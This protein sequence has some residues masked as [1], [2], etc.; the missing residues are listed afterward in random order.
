M[1]ALVLGALALNSSL[2]HLYHRGGG[3]RV[4]YAGLPFM[5][6][7]GRKNCYSQNMPGPKQEFV[8]APLIGAAFL[9]VA[10]ACTSVPV[11]ESDSPGSLSVISGDLRLRFSSPVNVYLRKVDDTRLGIFKNRVRVSPGSHVL[12]VDCEV[13]D[14]GGTSRY[15]LN[16]TTV[17][18]IDYRLQAV[19]ASG[20]RRCSAVEMVENPH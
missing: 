3:R 13:E 14:A 20:N 7:S 2:A 18:G 8:R 9:L 11:G 10:G 12:L 16:V 1:M 5:R 6:G 17:A 19:L 15:V 4:I